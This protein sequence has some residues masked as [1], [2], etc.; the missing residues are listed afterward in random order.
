MR[1]MKRGGGGWRTA[2]KDR[3]C[4]RESREINVRRE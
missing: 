4:D 3:S 1:D 2:G